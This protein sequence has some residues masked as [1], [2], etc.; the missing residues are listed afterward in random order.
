[1]LV[2]PSWLQVQVLTSASCRPIPFGLVSSDSSTV[3]SPLLFC[4]LVCDESLLLPL[5][6]WVL[7]VW[8]MFVKRVDLRRLLVGF[9]DAVC[10]TPIPPKQASFVAASSLASRLVVHRHHNRHALYSNR[11]LSN[12]GLRWCRLRIRLGYSFCGSTGYKSKRQIPPRR[13]QVVDVWS[14][15]TPPLRQIAACLSKIAF[16]FFFTTRDNT[17]W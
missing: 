13:R 16:V 9:G 5:T 3:I 12:G 1:M 10:F 6:L 7:V 11:C 14:L 4:W 15:E 17:T 8:L 2:H